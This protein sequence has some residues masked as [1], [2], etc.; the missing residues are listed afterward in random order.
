M[1]AFNKI[2]KF[3]EDLASKVHNLGSDQ[4][5]IYYSNTTP[6][7]AADAVKADL[8]EIA[9]GNGYTGPIDTQNTLSRTG[10]VTSII[11]TD[12]VTTASGAVGPFRYVVLQNTTPTSPLDPLIGW[13][14]YA[15]AVTLANGETFTT[16]FGSSLFTLT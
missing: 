5:E 6:D 14:D 2:E 12:T 1:A 11:G 9:T 16:D 10:G 3:T 15:S 4:L 7:A 8:A 13:W